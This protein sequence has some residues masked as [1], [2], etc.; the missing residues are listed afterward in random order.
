[1]SINDPAVRQELLSLATLDELDLEEYNI[2]FAEIHVT[3]LHV[4]GLRYAT[5]TERLSKLSESYLLE[6]GVEHIYALVE[7]DKKNLEAV[8]LPATVEVA[9]KFAD[10][11]LDPDS[12]TIDVSSIDD[13]WTVLG[14]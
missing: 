7:L 5:P 8:V 4:Y 3:Q 10:L 2:D 14:L 1:M 11:T 12:I 13:A 6:Q 9:T